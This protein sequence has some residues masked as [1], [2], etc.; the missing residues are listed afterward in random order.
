MTQNEKLKRHQYDEE[1]AINQ[2]ANNAILATVI[3]TTKQREQ[4]T[5]PY[6]EKA[7]EKI[8]PMSRRK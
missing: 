1:L 4:F 2:Q 3:Y 8:S 7:H 6:T 5:E